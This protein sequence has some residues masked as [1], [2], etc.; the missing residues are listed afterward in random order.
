MCKYKSKPIVVEAV[1]YLGEGVF[2]VLEPPEWVIEA[3]EKGILYVTYCATCGEN[4][5]NLKTPEG[6]LVV[7]MGCY[8]IKGIKGELSTCK[9]YI[10]EAMYDEIIED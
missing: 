6:D 4:L 9:S 5:L 2:D 3:F 1:R 8:I 7:P 10:F